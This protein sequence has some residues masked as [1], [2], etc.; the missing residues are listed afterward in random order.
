MVS[1]IDVISLYPSLKSDDSANEVKQ[2]VMESE[3]EVNIS[4]PK[5]LAVFLRKTLTSQQIASKRLESLIPFKEKKRKGDKTSSYPWIF[6]KDSYSKRKLKIM[7]AKALSVAVK[8][9]MESNVYMFDSEIRVQLDGGGIGV[10]L[11]GI[12][13]EI[14]MIKCHLSFSH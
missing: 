13:A 3:I 8:V 2:V 1:D 4:D 10:Q 5:E 12:L 7:F 14:K 9:A 11:T 6:P